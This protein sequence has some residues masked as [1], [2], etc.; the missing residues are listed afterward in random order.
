VKGEGD[1][2]GKSHMSGSYAYALGSAVTSSV[3][4]ESEKQVD[5]NYS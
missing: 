3:Y 5:V 4:T 1:C 2:L